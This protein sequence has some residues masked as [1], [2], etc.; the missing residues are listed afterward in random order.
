MFKHNFVNKT[1][2]S[3][4]AISVLA[5]SLSADINLGEISQEDDGTAL[6]KDGGIIRL[7]KVE[8]SNDGSDYATLVELNLTI[9]S[10]ENNIS[11]LKNFVLAKNADAT[12]VAEGSS[13]LLI[14]DDNTSSAVSIE[15]IV[16]LSEVDDQGLK[17]LDSE[18]NANYIVSLNY[19]QIVGIAN[20]ELNVTLNSI[21]VKDENNESK[22]LDI[23]KTVSSLR[24]DAVAPEFGDTNDSSKDAVTQDTDLS[25][26]FTVDINFTENIAD[27]S[28]D[29]TGLNSAFAITDGLGNDIKIISADYSTENKTLTLELNNSVPNNDSVIGDVT[30]AYSSDSGLLKDLA[31]NTV[32]DLEARIIYDDNI[33]PTLESVQID[34]E[35]SKSGQITFSEPIQVDNISTFQAQGVNDNQEVQILNLKEVS[36]DKN[37]KTVL[38]FETNVTV[39]SGFSI[40]FLNNTIVKDF[41]GN[42]NNESSELTATFTAGDLSGMEIEANKWN[43]I[44]LPSNK[45]TTS[46]YM[47][48]TGAVQ[49]IWG[50]ENSTWT[51]F[52][53]VL[54]AGQGYWV[55]GSVNTDDFNTTLTTGFNAV[56]V[57][58]STIILNNSSDEWQLLGTG[59]ENLSWKDAYSQIQD[60]CN[61][62]SIFSYDANNSWNATENIPAHSGIWVKQE[63][64]SK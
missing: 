18:G 20:G 5:S 46:R 26:G 59:D 49:T 41:G 28:D 56:E 64:C 53:T 45:L 63:N 33:S 4:A 22:K 12:K 11:F 35:D 44:A 32:A 13:A 17:F 6:S 30:L 34:F 15:K 40:T 57:N 23:S 3:F 43:L 14:Q 47:Q 36:T 24:I 38:S 42:E 54:K 58:S 29:L 8:I 39:G 52:P 1:A 7:F 16:D 61:G 51:K 55:K 21:T 9:S 48:Q 2:L 60:G 31:G 25:D 10:N 37:A 50:Y 27:P 62:V 19:D